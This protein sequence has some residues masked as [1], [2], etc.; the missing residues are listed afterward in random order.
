MNNKDHRIGQLTDDDDDDNDDDADGSASDLCTAPLSPLTAP[1]FNGDPSSDQRLPEMRM[2]F[3][4][5]MMTRGM[6][7]IEEW[8]D[9]DPLWLDDEEGSV[10][11]DSVNKGGQ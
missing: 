11:T 5:M 2:I 6:M 4:S 7:M 9:E 1:H 3:H 10:E 8:E